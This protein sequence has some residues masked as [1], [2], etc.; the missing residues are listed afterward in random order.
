MRITPNSQTD[1]QPKSGPGES[2]STAESLNIAKLT[3]NQESGSLGTNRITI[4][5]IGPDAQRRKAVA[6][7]LAAWPAG[8]TREFS[9][10][11]PSLDDV[12]RLL[13]QNYDVIIIDLD[14]NPEYALDLVESICVNGQATVMVYSAKADSE[15]LVR[16]M[17]AGAREFLTTPFAP[18]VMAEAL[19][20][21][22]VRR[23]VPRVVAVAAPP[24]QTKK[25]EGRFLVFLGAKGGAGVT[26]LACN[27]AVSLVQESG[28][29][30]LL[31]DFDLPFGSAAIDLGITA[32]YSTVNALQ[33]S[34]RLDSSFL[35]RLVVKHSSGLFVL[36]APGKVADSNFSREEIDKLLDLA[37]QEYD[38]VVVD[39]GCRLDLTATALFG[40]ASTVYLVTQVGVPELRNSNV[41]ITEFFSSGV[42][43]L[44]IVLN[45]Y[46]PRS[47][48]I[49]EE[50][51]TKAL[52]RPAQ[53]RIPCDYA[54]TR[55]M[56]NLATPLATED[57]P[58]S[59]AIRDM[60]RA[61]CGLEPEGEK[62]SPE[63]KKRF[64]S[65]FG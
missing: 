14:S 18:G 24:P 44:E 16:C 48:G 55:R 36:A 32:E 11:P 40:K 7:A 19:V 25:T 43:D 30:T 4:A 33:N 27:Y 20:R 3:T 61:V 45:R 41:L 47:M 60:A 58:I 31:I 50:H 56:Q 59:R 35:S 17:R 42:P 51:I 21:A 54:T 13:E 63:K 52:T 57:S 6:A 1:T 29:K 49:D 34:A 10:Y 37:R 9:S 26:T 8:E 12:P 22:S 38:Y 2:P 53:W 39:A 28:L 5:L 23:P 64:V 46:M 62:K 65:L 15:L